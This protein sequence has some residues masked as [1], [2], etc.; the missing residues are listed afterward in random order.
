MP[1]L[2]M[3]LLYIA[4]LP[5]SQGST[6]TSLGL[7]AGLLLACIPA[8]RPTRRLRSAVTAGLVGV[9]V[10][11]LAAVHRGI[12][13]VGLTVAGLIVTA[14]YVAFIAFHV[15]AAVVRHRRVS[16]NT[17]SAPSAST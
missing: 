16:T 6:L 10:V 12:E 11:R 2:F 5:F 4:T 15:F 3:L 8:V 7:T 17:L 1:L 9:M 13:D 14:A